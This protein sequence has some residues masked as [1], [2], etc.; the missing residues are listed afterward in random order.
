VEVAA[1]SD[2]RTLQA[3]LQHAQQSKGRVFHLLDCSFGKTQGVACALSADEHFAMVTSS[4][5]PKVI[6]VAMELR[7]SFP[8]SLWL[9]APHST[10][11][12]MTRVDKLMDW[13][14]GEQGV[15]LIKEKYVR[16]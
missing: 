11:E 2:R 14:H 1:S 12:E 7:K 6:E 3:T 13:G 15:L 5:H 10:L 8:R 16:Y 4:P 9:H